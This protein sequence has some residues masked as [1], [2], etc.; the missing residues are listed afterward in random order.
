MN[1]QLTLKL[2]ICV[3]EISLTKYSICRFKCITKCTVVAAR[4]INLAVVCLE[5]NKF[6][7]YKDSSSSL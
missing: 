7:W 3:I 1:E 4:G 2:G 6:I 5:R